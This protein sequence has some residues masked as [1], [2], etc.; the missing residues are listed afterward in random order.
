MRAIGI[1]IPGLHRAQLLGP[2]RE[3]PGRLEPSPV[4]AEEERHRPVQVAYRKVRPAIAVQIS[5]GDRL[6]P[7]LVVDRIDVRVADRDPVGER[8][9]PADDLGAS[10]GREEEPTG[11]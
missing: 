7:L 8:T 9:E 6:R 2:G 11:S 5:R 4:R 10:L 3:M 1:E